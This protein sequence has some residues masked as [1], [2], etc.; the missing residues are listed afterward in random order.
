MVIAE[1]H[2][3]AATPPEVVEVEYMGADGVPKAYAIYTPDLS[4]LISARREY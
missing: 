3:P 1:L 2:N 4:E